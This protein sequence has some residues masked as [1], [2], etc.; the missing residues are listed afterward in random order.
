MPDSAG[1]YEFLVTA[2]ISC[3][4]FTSQDV[5]GNGDSDAMTDGS[6]KRATVKNL[7][8]CTDDIGILPHFPLPALLLIS[9]LSSIYAAWLGLEAVGRAAVFFFVPTFLSITVVIAGVAGTFHLSNLMPLWGLGAKN[10]LVQ[11]LLSAGAFG[12]VPALA[13]LK[14]YVRDLRGLPGRGAWSVIIAGAILVVGVVALA[15]IFP[16]PMSQ[17]KVEPLG[18]MARAVFL[19]RFLQRLEALFTFTWFFAISVQ[20]SFSYLIAL[21]LLSQLCN[22]GTYR[23][24]IPAMASLTFGIAGIPE[25]TL[26]AAQILDGLF[27]TGIG[28]MTLGLGWGLFIV[29]L[30]RGISR[31]A[32]KDT[33]SGG[34]APRATGGSHEGK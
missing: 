14:S 16:Y 31:T 10:T 6:N 11:G 7:P 22:A 21:L 19:G 2:H 13:V 26:R 9:I 30:A 27:T 33:R 17:R 24:F 3:D 25:N 8:D 15:G 32:K 20:A 1:I 34:E 29:A 23:P 4:M 28:N 12:G 5:S 18:I